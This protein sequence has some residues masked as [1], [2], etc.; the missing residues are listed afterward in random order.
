LSLPRGAAEASAILL[1]W[2]QVSFSTCPHFHGF[3]RGKWGQVEK[4]T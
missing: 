4:L 3:G 2:G 1:L